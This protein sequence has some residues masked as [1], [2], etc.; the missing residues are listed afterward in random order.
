MTD[1]P[2]I[3]V[4]VICHGEPRVRAG[5]VENALMGNLFHWQQEYA[6][7]LPDEAVI[8]S[9]RE[10]LLLVRLPIETYIRSV[11]GSEMNA[12]APAEFLRAHA[13]V[14][15]SWAAGKVLRAHSTDN[16]AM[17]HTDSEIRQWADTAAHTD[18]DVC[19]DDHCQRWQGVQPLDRRLSEALESTRGL[20]LTDDSGAICD[21]RYSKCCGGT[22]EIFSTCWQDRDYTYLQSVAD[23]WCDPSILTDAE[24]VQLHECILKDY[25]IGQT[26]DYYRWHR[27]VGLKETER[28]LRERF[29]ID[30][31]AIESLEPLHRGASGRISRLRVRGSR[32]EAVIG[33]ELAVRRLLAP[34]HLL[35]SAFEAE[36]AG[37]DLL[38]H[39]RGWGH[40]VG[41]CQT[42]AAVMALRGY[43]ADRILAHYYPG[44]RLTDIHTLDFNDYTASV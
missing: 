32:G 31:G 42:G 26:P 36:R 15:R 28:R 25:D 41:M 7:R 23:P 3:R 22:T 6:L 20:V 44:S 39:G 13:I 33:K 2:Q 10:G 27:R 4:G 17:V 12:L 38:L 11:V 43:T 5:I 37:D 40:G 18:Y 14:S 8:L 35:S 30:V 1:S 24:R 29:S 19:N 34:T 16:S 21:T 9:R